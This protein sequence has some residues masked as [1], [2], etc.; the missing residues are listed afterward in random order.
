MSLACQAMK[1]VPPQILVFCVPMYKL[2]EFYASH[3]NSITLQVTT[4]SADVIK[5]AYL[6]FFHS[7]VVKTTS[8]P[9]I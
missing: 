2:A 3:I 4:T 7:G 9:Q 5:E 8:L 1:V 6:I